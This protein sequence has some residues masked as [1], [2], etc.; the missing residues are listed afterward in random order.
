MRLGTDGYIDLRDPRRVVTPGQFDPAEVEPLP[1]ED[2]VAFLLTHSFPGHRKIVRPLTREHRK[3]IRMASWAETVA[4]RMAIVDRVWRQITEQV[5]PPADSTTPQ[6]LQV[7]VCGAR[8][9]P[10][11]LHGAVTRAI[12]SEGLPADAE[13][14][15]SLRIDL[16]TS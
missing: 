8:S 12:P 9:W 15:P 6:L 7:V 16:R 2:S 4:E 10:I 3:R 14:D 5:L 11:Y 13:T 1:E